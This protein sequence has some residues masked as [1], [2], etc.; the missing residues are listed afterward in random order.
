[1]SIAVDEGLPGVAVEKLRPTATPRPPRILKIYIKDSLPPTL[2]YAFSKCGS[3][4]V[5]Q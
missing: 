3:V 1:M 4:T 2:G 5:I